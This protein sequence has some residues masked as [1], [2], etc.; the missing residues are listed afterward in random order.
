MG[1]FEGLGGALAA[2]SQLRNVTRNS[3]EL[4]CERK[5]F[6]KEVCLWIM[7]FIPL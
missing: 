7:N 5:G 2:S 6:F 3:G 1:G 4:A